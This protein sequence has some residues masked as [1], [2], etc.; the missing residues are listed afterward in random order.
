MRA[1]QGT[2][3]ARGANRALSH[4]S[5]LTDRPLHPT[6][7]RADARAREVYVAV[8]SPPSTMAALTQ[9]PRRHRWYR[10]RRT[11][12]GARSLTAVAEEIVDLANAGA[13]EADARRFELY[14]RGI[15]DD[16]FAGAAHRSL[17]E[18]DR[19]ECEA[20]H[21]ENRLTLVLRIDGETPERLDH[22]AHANERESALQLER[23]RLL[24]RRAR[25]L[26]THGAAATLP[27]AA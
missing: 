8:T 4:P 5:A 10:L 2:P 27:P 9:S 1:K 24:R 6:D 26:R 3:L 12:T 23:A 16:C 22:A 11:E 14:V 7:L 17:D 19:E 13:P 20:E 15:I 25:W 18:L 21:I